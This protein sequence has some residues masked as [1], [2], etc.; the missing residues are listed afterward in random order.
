LIEEVL[1][2]GAVVVVTGERVRYRL[3]PMNPEE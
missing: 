1:T 3:L 2:A